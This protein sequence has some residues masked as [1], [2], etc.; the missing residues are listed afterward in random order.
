MDGQEQRESSQAEL[1]KL[2]PMTPLKEMPEEEAEEEDE[3]SAGALHSGSNNNSIMGKMKMRVSSIFPASLSDWFSPSSKGGPESAST[4]SA[5]LR[6]PQSHQSNGRSSTK[7]KRGR[8]RIM[9]A[10]ADADALDL[11]DGSDAKGLNYEEVAL[12]DNIAEHDLAAEDEQTRRSEYNVFLLRKDSEALAAAGGEE[13]EAEEDDLEEEEEE[14]DEEDDEEEQESLLQSAAVQP[15]RRRMELETTV[16]LPNMRRLPLLSSTPAAPLVAATSSSASQ[17]AGS[18]SSSQLAP[19]RRNHLNLYGSQRQREPAYNFFTGNEAA[20]GSTGDL[21]HSIRRSLNIPFGGGS[22]TTSHHSFSSLPNHKRPSLLGQRTHRRDLTMD[23]TGVG[24]GLS[25]VTNADGDRLDHLL[26]ITKTNNNISNNNNNN[27]NVIKSKTRRTDLSLAAVGGVDSHSEGD[28]ND[29]HDNG[30]G[31]DGLRPSHHN[32]NSN[33]EFYGNLQSSKSIFNRNTAATAQPAHRNSTWSL[34]SL[35]LRRRFNASIYGSTSALSD[36]RLLSRSASTSGSA[37][38]SSSPFYQGRTTFGGNSAN[39]RI[40][41]RSNLSSSAASSSLAINSGGSSPAHP[42]Q[43]PLSS[44]LGYGMK[45]VDMRPSAGGEPTNATIGKSGGKKSGSGLSN[46]TLRILN[47]LDSYSTPLIDAKRMGSTLKEHQSSRQQRQGAPAT[48]YPRPTYAQNASRSGS[49]PSVTAELAELRSNKL[50]VPT[51]QQL[52]ERRRLHRV[53]QNS[54]DLVQNQNSS[55]VRPQNS[56][57]KIN[58]TAAAPYVAPIDHSASHSHH[59]NKMRSRLSHQPRSKEPRAEL[60]E[61]PLPLDLPQISFPDMASAPKFDLVIKP[62]VSVTKL[63]PTIPTSSNKTNISSSSISTNAK[64]LPNFLANPQYASPTVNFSANGNMAPTSGSKPTRRKF[65]FSEPIPMSQDSQENC[66]NRPADI[67]R[68]YSFPSPASLDEEEQQPPTEPAARPS[69]PTM[70]GAPPLMGFG[71]QFKKSSN[72]WECDV[73]MVRNKAEVSKCVACET[74]KPGATTAQAALVQAAPTTPA[75]VP[76]GGGFGDRFK[77]AANAWDCDACMLSNKA[78]ATKCIACETPRKA[79]AAQPPKVDILPLMTN[80]LVTGSG[81]GNAFKP[82]ANTWECQTCL[83]MNQSSAAECIACQTPNSQPRS[84]SS[85]SESARS[86]SASSSSSSSSTGS[87]S[88]SA[89]S[90]SSVICISSSSDSVKFG[91]PKQDAGFQQLVAAQKVASW[92]CDACMAQNDMSR[93]KCICCEQL[94][95]GAATPATMPSVASAAFSGS[96]GSTNSGGSA[97]PKFS[98]GFGTVKEVVKPAVST[99]ST[100]ATPAVANSQFSFGFGQS[101]QGKDVADSKKAEPAKG[102]FTFG[103]PKVEQPKETKVPSGTETTAA[104]APAAAPVLPFVFKGPT[105]AATTSSTTTTTSS[106]FAITTTAS[107]A[108]GGFS[109][110][111]PTSTSTVSSST[112]SSSASSAAVKPMF[113]L[114]GAG[115]SGSGLGTSVVSSTS[116]SQTPMAKSATLSFGVSSNT[117]TTTTTSSTTFALTPAAT[118]APASAA[119]TLAPAPAATLSFGGQPK[120]A[121][122]APA[123]GGFFFGQTP[124]ATPAPSASTSGSSIFGA[125]AA[126]ATASTSSITAAATTTAPAAAAPSLAPSATPQ[127]F[128][129]W[130]EKKAETTTSSASKPFAFGSSSG[131]GASAAPSFG[132]WSSNGAAAKSNSIAVTSATVSSSTTNPVFGSSFVFGTP[133][134]STTSSSSTSSSTPFGST[135]T[136]AAATPSLGGNGAFVGVFGNVGNSLVAPGAPAAT[137]PAPAAVPQIANMF[138]NP[139]PIAAAAPVFGSSSGISTSGGFGAAAA[140]AASTATTTQ[141]GSKLAF[142]FGG[143]DAATPAA[144][145]A[146]F[147]FGNTTNA[148]PAKPA[149]NFTGSAPSSTPQAAPFSFSTNAAAPT[150]LSGGDSQSQQRVF[151]FGAPPTATAGTNQTSGAGGAASSSGGGPPMFTFGAAAPQMQSTPNANAPFQF[152]AG[153]PAPA[154]IFAFNPPAAGNSAQNSQMVRRKIRHPMRRL[155]PR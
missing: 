34:N 75:I 89:G 67:S 95:P 59:T 30:D 20:E 37:S 3:S 109:F 35:S 81:F 57:E 16:N 135:A 96:S 105:T 113:S 44:G 38:A 76:L 90:S 29:Y 24:L 147:K 87:S 40:F 7:R 101:N 63:E 142:N 120:P 80:N 137:I 123:A 114:S 131:P 151:Q 48:P 88:G 127:L 19:H 78:E 22:T 27:N 17:I 126:S 124:A 60:E 103:A 100:P 79:A 66:V 139:T 23:E 104:P 77:K 41:S 149:F 107:P 49:V 64:Q 13:D 128:G 25:S 108:L 61:A 4:T 11:D 56:Q 28:A 74:A 144:S 92:D 119:A 86:P 94:K 69:Q 42:L 146:P 52:L 106:T 32:S 58:P 83:V 84:S 46:T 110:G 18:R 132:G 73:C 102:G 122:S 47:L 134:S 118:P 65:S 21:P 50:L 68:N 140:A 148:P 8:R 155:P 99:S 97:V 31:H 133:A 112:A 72:E 26:R 12:A 115:S 14:G 116:S 55:H 111:A 136:T 85:N 6:Q 117:V 129:N 70:N 154:N 82:K 141:P 121:E 2:H 15:K 143:A 125:P 152:S 9:L 33:L 91:A 153:S 51:M 36:S 53:T 5:N 71:N 54:R 1:A 138:G 39:N 45:P 130:G 150:S 145:G 93:I 98:F 10:E 62:T 43:G